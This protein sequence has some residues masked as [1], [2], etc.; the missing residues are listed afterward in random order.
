[1]ELNPAYFVDGCAYVK[2]MADEMAMP[3]LFG[4]LELENQEKGEVA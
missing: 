1:M 4:V 2:A 3:D